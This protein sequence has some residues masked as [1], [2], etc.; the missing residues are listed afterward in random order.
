MAVANA[1]PPPAF[2]PFARSIAAVCMAVGGMALVGWWFSKPLFNSVAPGLGTLKPNTARCFILSG[3][4]L[5]G[6]PAEAGEKGVHNRAL[7]HIQAVAA[8]L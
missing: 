5:A 6:L 7:S 1:G 8:L 3:L 2:M 4:A